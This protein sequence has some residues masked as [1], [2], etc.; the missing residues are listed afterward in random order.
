MRRSAIVPTFSFSRLEHI[1]KTPIIKSRSA[2]N[3]L[4]SIN[5]LALCFGVRLLFLGWFT[6]KKRQAVANLINAFLD[7]FQGFSLSPFP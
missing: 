3:H 4:V 6:R 1:K 5:G 7:E 2:G